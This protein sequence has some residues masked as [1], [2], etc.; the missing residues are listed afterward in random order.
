MWLW[1]PAEM[2][3]KTSERPFIIESLWR[4][5]KTIKTNG[6]IFF[7]FIAS[8]CL[9]LQE[10][11]EIIFV[12]QISNI[13]FNI[14]WKMHSYNLTLLI[15]RESAFSRS[16]YH[17]QA[18]TPHFT[19][20]LWLLIHGVLSQSRPSR[21]HVMTDLWEKGTGASSRGFLKNANP[22]SVKLWWVS[23]HLLWA[24]AQSWW[25]LNMGSSLFLSHATTLFIPSGFFLK[26]QSTVHFCFL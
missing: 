24:C 11:E 17:F 10:H 1:I 15:K 13:L 26:Q 5:M 19:F 20:H 18:A 2:H 25:C 14:G 7:A 4:D 6:L 3:P 8:R 23:P 21:Q 16:K 22:H 12:V 9:V